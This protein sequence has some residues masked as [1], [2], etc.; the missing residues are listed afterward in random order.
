MGHPVI[1]R[2]ATSVFPVLGLFLL[3]LLSLYVLGDTA[4]SPETFGKYY[5]WLLALNALGVL[6]ISAL[7]AINAIQLI[8]QFRQ[9]EAGS[10]LTVKLVVML[11]V[12]ILLLK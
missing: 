8:R 10:R 7:I 9:R 4:Q 5:S 2:L 1:Q 11:V 3:L 6:I 12:E